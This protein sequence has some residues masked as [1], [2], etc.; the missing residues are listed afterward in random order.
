MVSVCPRP[1]CHRPPGRCPLLHPLCC[2]CPAQAPDLA[3]IPPI[4]LPG[5]RTCKELLTRGHFLSGWHTIYLPDCRPLTVLCDMDT[6]GGGWTV[7]CRGPRDGHVACG[8]W[9]A[10]PGGSSGGR[11][12][13][14]G[15]CETV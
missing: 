14:R 7:S 15:L 2:P 9:W 11:S 13:F 10:C 3:S 5:P 12:V 4:P 1:R 8:Q 6:D